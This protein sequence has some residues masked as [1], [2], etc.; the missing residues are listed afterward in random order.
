MG[1]EILE[2]AHLEASGSA[3]VLRSTLAGREKKQDQER[4]GEDH[5]QNGRKVRKMEVKWSLLLQVRE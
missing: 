3:P 2:R 4:K 5:R 1:G